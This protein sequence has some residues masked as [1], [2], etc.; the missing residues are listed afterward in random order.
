MGFLVAVGAAKGP[1]LVEGLQ[2][3]RDPVAFQRYVAD[4]VGGWGFS[5]DPDGPQRDQAWASAHPGLLLAAGERAC[6]WLAD[7]H[8]APEVDPTGD[9]SSGALAWSYLGVDISKQSYALE[10]DP[11]ARDIG[12]QLSPVGRWTVVIGA[13]EH[14]CWSTREAKIAPTTLEP[15]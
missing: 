1:S 14:L 10:E 7:R 11:G 4:Y 13:W 15:D 12:L 8:D 5:D 9:S 2:H 3:P 6:E